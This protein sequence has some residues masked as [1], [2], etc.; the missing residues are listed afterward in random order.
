ME[1]VCNFNY[2]LKS[3]NEQSNKQKRI[4]F[5][6]MWRGYDTLKY[7]DQQEG[8]NSPLYLIQKRLIKKLNSKESTRDWAKDNK[9]KADNDFR[10]KTLR[11]L[12]LV[13]SGKE[14]KDIKTEIGKKTLKLLG[15]TEPK[16]YS[17][18]I[19][20]LATTI[21]VEAGASGKN[22]MRAIA[23]IIYNRKKAINNYR[24]NVIKKGSMLNVIDVAL[25]KNQFSLW[26][27][28]QKYSKEEMVKRAMKRWRPEN[29]NYW[30][31]AVKLAKILLMISIFAD[32]TK[33]ATHYYNP[34]IVT[35][36]WAKGKSW[37][38]H[39]LKT[40]H[41]FGRDTKTNWAKN[42]VSRA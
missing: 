19:K 36:S 31:Y 7:G 29:S 23:N 11:A 25:S 39:N 26:N 4:T 9:F 35:P 5:I 41:D 18:N 20:I 40:V 13:L 27:I 17:L 42:P 37:I 15:F 3:I 30:E 21:T 10:G 16:L 1:N 22:E 28:Y 8:E 33:G 38:S 6:D 14:Y 2:W 24:K 12:G 34:K 32:N